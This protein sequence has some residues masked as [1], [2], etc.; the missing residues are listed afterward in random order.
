MVGGP[1]LLTPSYANSVLQ[2]LYFCAPLREAVME[3]D[4]AHVSPVVRR[5]DTLHTALVR[6]F[7]TMAREASRIS[8]E[9]GCAADAQ[10][11]DAP[12]KREASGTPAI[13]SR[14][15]NTE[16]IKTFLETLMRNC[17]LFDMSM[18]HDA[19]EFLNFTLNQV[20]E[21]LE[22]LHAPARGAGSVGSGSAPATRGDDDTQRTYVHDLF[23][24]VLT[25][26]TK[27]LTC[28]NVSYRDEAFLD[29]S[30]N[31]SPNTSL[32]SC[33]RQFSESEMLHGRNKF[34]CDAC[35]SLQEAEKRM[36]IRHAPNILALHLKRFIWDE[37]VQAYVKHACRVVFPLD[38]RLFNM[39]DQ[40]DNPD[41]RYELFAI[42]IHVGAGANQGH[43]ISIVKIG[44]RW[45]L[46]DDETVTFIAESDIA[47]YYGDAPEI[48]SAYVLFYRAVELDE[49]AAHAAAQIT[50]HT[51]AASAAAPAAPSAAPP[52]AAP[53]AASAT[54]P[55]PAPSS[56]ARAMPMP[57]AVPVAG[58][59][60]PAS[61]S[62]HAPPTWSPTS[63]SSQATLASSAGMAPAVPIPPAMSPTLSTG[64]APVLS[65]SPGGGVPEVMSVPLP[66][67][68][69][70][71]PV[72]SATP[73]ASATP[74][75][76]PPYRGAGT[77]YMST[78]P[79]MMDLSPVARTA[80]APATG[81]PPAADVPLR[82]TPLPVP[83]RSPYRNSMYAASP[84]H[85]DG[86]A[87]M[88][89]S[90]SQRASFLG[91]AAPAIRSTDGAP[92]SRMTPSI[93]LA[94]IPTSPPSAG[95]SAG[96]P[97]GVPMPVSPRGAPAPVSSGPEVI[98]VP[99][100]RTQAVPAPA[101]FPNTPSPTMPTKMGEA[102][103]ML[104]AASTAGPGAAPAPAAPA[105]AHRSMSASMPRSHTMH[106]LSSRSAAT[107]EVRAAEA[108]APT[109]RSWL[110][111]ALRIDRTDKN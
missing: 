99:R 80:P 82:G 22:A 19:H 96:A 27:C 66:R 76:S 73:A 63:M 50:H 111:R 5:S 14:T 4:A 86:G 13:V 94:H 61:A 20:G 57:I 28:E 81:A 71:Q 101:V 10:S 100:N 84:T 89:R 59:G 56:S 48:G 24:G 53:A 95:V 11:G 97:A 23:Q 46:F 8:I 39:S 32:S 7:H 72:E 41:R 43:Y 21:D 102:V 3:A 33:L 42:V 17:D 70:Q 31:V 51:P 78:T 44:Q 60:A 1:A 92:P 58:R 36:K 37:R 106:N 6:L 12:A 64:P 67:A 98:A 69:A 16:A 34:F 110:N 65:A 49:R 88:T 18:H 91:E 109:K 75:A 90:M 54:G 25:N 85:G 30:V 62:T 29:L 103:P 26:E 105:D 40:A 83:P 2:A 107:P 108:P 104:R 87:S 79:S 45:A 55:P 9:V 77:S 47:K 52:A 35:A 15:V 68:R 93:S 38:L 74:V